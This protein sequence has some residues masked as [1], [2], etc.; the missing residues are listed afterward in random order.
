MPT[1]TLDGLAAQIADDLARSDLST[2]IG[3]AILTAI[4][5][6]KSKRFYFNET[7]TTTF[8]TVAG[9]SNYAS[10]DDTDIPLFLEIDEMFLTDSSGNVFPLGEQDDP[11]ELQWLLGNGASTG[12][13][14][15]WAYYDSSFVL[16][17]IPDGVYTIT[18]MGHIEVAPPAGDTAGNVWMT[19]AFELLRCD[20]KA[21][22]YTHTIKNAPDKA[23]AMVDAAQGAKNTLNS[24]TN[25]RVATGNIERTSF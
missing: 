8:V 11:G 18:P 23:A 14:F 12:R 19:E 1:Y 2:Q 21:Y 24:A 10:G 9:Q 13:P 25:R 22:L 15:R 20:A 7:R 5:N 16:Y 4:K 17:P 3:D 6:R